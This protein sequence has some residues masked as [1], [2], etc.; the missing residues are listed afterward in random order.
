MRNLLKRLSILL[1]VTM[2]LTLLSAQ[3]QMAMADDVRAQ[4]ASSVVY[5]TVDEAAAYV[6]EQM[7][8]RET[9]ITV[10]ISKSAVTNSDSI[11]HEIMD[12][13]VEYKLGDSGQAGDALASNSKE[14]RCRYS[15][16]SSSYKINYTVRY[17]TTAQQEAQLTEAVNS[18]LTGLNLDDKTDYEKIVS[19]YDY[20]CNNVDY[21]YEGLNDSSNTIKYTAY[22][23]LIN[24][25][26]VCEGYSVLFYRMC[27]DAGIP[28]RIISGTGNG[29]PHAWNIVGINGYYYNV[30][31]TW[32][33]QDSVTRHDYFLKNMEDFSDHARNEEYSTIEFNTAFPMAENS[34]M[35]YSS[36]AAPLDVANYNY[37]F[38]TIDGTDVSTVPSG[39]AKVLI[40]F[41]SNCGNSQATISSI[42][43][44][45][46]SD[47]DII[48]INTLT[49]GD[50]AATESFRNTYGNNS[51][52]FC[53]Y[54]GW[55]STAMWAY[56]SE[57]LGYTGS[58]YWPVI[59]YIDSNDKLQM[60]TNGY[61]GA[62]TIRNYVNY[63]CNGIQSDV[64]TVTISNPNIFL[65]SLT[66]DNV[67]AGM[68]YEASA[69]T[70]MEFSWYAS[71]D[72]INWFCVQDWTVNNEWVNWSPSLYGE[73]HL[74]GM[75]RVKGQPSTIV[76]A[77]ITDTFN[78][79]I[80]GKCQMPYS[81]EGGGYLIGV[82]TYENPEQAYTYEMLI[83]DCTL[84]AEGK[85]AWVYTT[86]RCPVSEGNALWTI[87]QPMYGYYWTLF[88][89]YDAGGNMI[90][91]ACYAFQNI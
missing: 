86:G 84:L 51:M 81:G 6:K 33:G 91:E 74:K 66:R 85:D 35:D 8:A 73:F 19:I 78:P 68:T 18:A 58:I 40:F 82:E 27:M 32:D 42:A 22:S 47:T 17:L 49:S 30:D 11:V 5:S 26:S 12:K 37:T 64:P 87:W 65:Y 72:N 76:E 50:E 7:I 13:A 16:D 31:V 56:A 9:S 29:G 48:C 14:W 39:K 25:K 59:A 57:M 44:S 21:D 62:G 89:V 45:D 71:K 20:I 38:T 88:R 54:A 77:V 79:H 43:N 15:S 23:A 24:G 69:K 1:A 53:A 4:A 80:K 28:V 60:V 34:Y 75:V 41:S 67:V 2:T 83:L 3:P 61:S 10:T 90:D 55:N 70:D 63:Y 52:D 46:F 36:L